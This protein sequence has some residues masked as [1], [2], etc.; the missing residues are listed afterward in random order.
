MR[1]EIAGENALILY[2][3]E[4]TDPRVSAQ[5]QRAVA[6]TEAR[7]GS[8]VIDLVPSYAS[9]LVIYDPLQLDHL[10][11]KRL[12]SDLGNSGE[13]EEVS[14]GSLIKLP[15]WYSSE[16]GPD[17]DALAERAGM[18]V[19]DVID[20]HASTEYRVY[21][22]GFAP[23][24]AYLGQ[25]D[26]RIAAPRLSTPRQVVP[27]GSVAIADRQTAIY[28]AASPGGW[29]LIGRCPTRMFNPEADPCM[30]VQVG[31]RVSFEPID[32]ERYL[33]LGGEL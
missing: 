29:N 32:K 27:R 26:E 4:E 14:E 18:S 8:A 12:L 5:V 30:P 28:P 2:F 23:G 6:E 21:A 1:I 10:Q 25:V 33:E 3:G 9:L 19:S 24:F 15:V 13:D 11:V 20:L 22:I 17:L 7:L 16:S 31:D